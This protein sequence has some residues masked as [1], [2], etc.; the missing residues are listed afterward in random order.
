[1]EA[2]QAEMFAGMMLHI[3]IPLL[4]GMGGCLG[5]NLKAGSADPG[6]DGLGVG[7]VA[8]N[9]GLFEQIRRSREAILTCVRDAQPF[10]RADSFRPIGFRN[11]SC[12]TLNICSR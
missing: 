9:P 7:T 10:H 2:M 5:N 11:C 1:M 4:D 12:H 8:I 6:C 3:G